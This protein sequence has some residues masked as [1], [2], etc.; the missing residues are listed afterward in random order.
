MASLKNDL[1]RDRTVE[2]SINYYDDHRCIG[3]A[4]DKGLAARMGGHSYNIIN[5]TDHDEIYFKDMRNDDH[6]V[7]KKGRHTKFLF[8][9]RKRQFQG[10]ERSLMQSCIK[11]PDSHP[12]ETMKQQR[13]VEVQLAQTEN[14]Q[15]FSGFQSR[16]AELF[17]VEGQPSKAE[18]NQRLANAHLQP[19]RASGGRFLATKGASLGPPCHAKRYSISNRKYANEAEKL[20]PR[21]AS[22]DDWLRRRGETMTRSTSAPS[23]ELADPSRSLDRAIRDDKRKEGSQR[24]TETAHF[25]P[26][27]AANTYCAPLDATPNGRRLAAEQRSCSVNRIENHDFAVTRKNN[28]YSAHDKL[29]RADPFFAPPRLA[30]THNS[31]K[32]DIINNERRWFRY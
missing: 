32:Y 22:R 12:R 23:I 14:A 11:A 30:G 21:N 17:G 10:D 24:M 13:R 4:G 26:W 19:H 25:A 15:S 6:C 20:R 9:D 1:L 7:D 16:C 28:H 3:T 8:G 5:N 18:E 29:T 31:V 27:S 2:G